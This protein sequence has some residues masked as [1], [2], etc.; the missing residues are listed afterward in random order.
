MARAKHTDRAA[1]RRRHRATL[2]AEPPITDEAVVV[3]ERGRPAL[4][5]ATPEPRRGMR[6]AFGAAFRPIDLRGDLAVLPQ[7]LRGRWFLV[8]VGVQI[9]AVILALTAAND[10]TSALTF[11]AVILFQYF[12]YTPP[13]GAAFLVGATAPRASWLLGAI[14]GLVA[15]VAYLGVIGLSSALTEDLSPEVRNA[16]ALYALGTGPAGGA[17]FASLAAWYLRFLRLAN[18][19]AYQ[20]RGQSRPSGRAKARPAARRR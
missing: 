11:P 6:Y 16:A 8:A 13:M 1:A 2:A 9:V 15:A 20:R 18:P 14:V 19:N 17:L 10:P 3:D 12:I 7:L 4:P 5:P